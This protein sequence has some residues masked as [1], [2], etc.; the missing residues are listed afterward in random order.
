M[1]F[2]CIDNPTD[3]LGKT[4]LDFKGS[5]GKRISTLRNFAKHFWVEM[6]TTRK[7]GSR[8]PAHARQLP[9]CST[10]SGRGSSRIGLP[11]NRVAVGFWKSCAVWRVRSAAAP[12]KGWMLP[13]RSWALLYSGMSPLIMSIRNS[14][15]PAAHPPGWVLFVTWKGATEPQS[16]G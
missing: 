9:R 13:P 8:F 7:T 15:V 10:P 1:P 11:G 12:C 14:T 5:H 16:L 6:R 3:L 2:L 4:L